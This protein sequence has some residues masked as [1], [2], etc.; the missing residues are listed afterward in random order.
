MEE[1]VLVELGYLGRIVLAGICGGVIGYE[2]QSKRKIAGL[3][4]H[5]IVA[6]SS[7]L[8]II[9]SKYGFQDVLDE[10][11]KLDPSRVAS[12]IVTAIGFLGSGMIFFR[13]NSVSG[14]T[15]SAG[16]WA[17]VG[18]GMA[19]GAGMY[20]V[21]VATTI[22]VLLVELFLG[23]K[24]VLSGKGKEL[25]DIVAECKQEDERP[26]RALAD[27]RKAVEECGGKI[28]RITVKKK[29]DGIMKVYM[30]AETENNWDAASFTAAAVS[31]TEIIKITV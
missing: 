12:G 20:A 26:G 18:V 7:A 4:T 1:W 11:V 10:Y 31:R 28:T 19:V 2:R 17:T 23:R 30:Q 16:V 24:G 22:I 25:R 5:V 27:L 3:R 29:E 9:L 15:T 13:N 14:L 8:M 21:G 6:V